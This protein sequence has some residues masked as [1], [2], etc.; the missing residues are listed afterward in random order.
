MDTKSSS[1]KLSINCY[2][3]EP[4]ENFLLLLSKPITTYLNSSK[5][6]FNL[7][8]K[9]RF[10][11][12]DLYNNHDDFLLMANT[13][14]TEGTT[15]EHNILNK[16]FDYN[17][18]ITKQNFENLSHYYKF[19]Q[20][21]DIKRN[22]INFRNTKQP[23]DIL[24]VLNKLKQKEEDNKIILENTIFTFVVFIFQYL[25][26]FEENSIKSN[27]WNYGLK[28]MCFSY[29]CFFIGIF[30][31][32]CQYIWTATLL[33]KIVDDFKITTEPIIIIITIISTIISLFYSYDTLC[34]YL[35]SRKLYKFLLKLY[36]DYP[37]ITLNN[38]IFDRHTREFY[39]QNNITMTKG[40]LKFY[41][42]ADFLS[43][44]LLPLII[45][46]INV[47]IIL[48]SENI[49]DAILNS[50]AVFFI[51][52]IDE[53]LYNLSND[54]LKINN[55]NFTQWI[56]SVIYCRHFPM[57]KDVFMFNCNNILKK[58][59]SSKRATILEKIEM[60]VAQSLSSLPSFRSQPQ[61]SVS[62][63][64]N[65]TKKNNKVD[66]MNSMNSMVIND[67]N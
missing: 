6:K 65:F 21:L 11:F 41:W 24:V 19:W 67:I 34:S 1:Y 23:E 45:P 13:R 52:Q 66:S 29:K 64:Y 4:A 37:E 9:W 47:F 35:Y 20:K 56:L 43:N 36:S 17:Y 39:K 46:I 55:I 8:S 10:Y 57:F 27:L 3:I 58:K 18:E 61:S 32:L 33:Y 51:I 12:I 50:I 26:Y 62:P 44:F 53:D 22:S 2:L 60:R 28:S 63:S 7:Y 5:D 40:I 16:E 25:N 48:N 49:L 54:E 38:N 15:L 42:Y 31:L 14:I 30:T 59:H